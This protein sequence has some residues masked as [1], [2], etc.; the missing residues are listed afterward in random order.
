M[1]EVVI[2]SLRVC[3]A[4]VFAKVAVGFV[5]TSS[6]LVDL[7]DNHSFD[8]HSAHLAG[9]LLRSESDHVGDGRE[10]GDLVIGALEA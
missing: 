9:D 5:G 1:L 4:K 3:R 2:C 8:V 6:F 10:L 7:P